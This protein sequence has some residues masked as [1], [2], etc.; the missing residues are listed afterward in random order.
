[1]YQIVDIH[2]STVNY[3]N[4]QICKL[5][6]LILR[7]SALN[8]NVNIND[9]VKEIRI[10]SNLNTNLWS[11]KFCHKLT[12]YFNSK[13]LKF[14]S[15]LIH[16]YTTTIYLYKYNNHGN[17][18]LQSLLHENFRKKN[19][20]A[21]THLVV[22]MS[23]SFAGLSLVVIWRTGS[24]TTHLCCWLSVDLV[25]TDDAAAA[26][27]AAVVADVAG[28]PAILRRVVSRALSTLRCPKQQQTRY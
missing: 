6:T 1:M 3:T 9:S 11:Y 2:L 16:P 10:L 4:T 25:D 8:L 14:T 15:K 23:V 21:V 26:A 27:P 5:Q 19:K 28:V 12:I 13:S 20:D 22:A 24:S 18:P 17:T 7:I